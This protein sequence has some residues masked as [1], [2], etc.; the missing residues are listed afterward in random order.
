LHERL[1][2]A[3]LVGQIRGWPLTTYNPNQQLVANRVMLVGD[4][5]GL[6]NP[7]NGEGIQYALLSGKW[8]S[9]TAIS[10]LDANDLKQE[11][12]KHCFYLPQDKIIGFQGSVKISQLR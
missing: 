2:N 1:K 9:E 4:A 6:V 10:C 11:A 12:P 7:L 8:A 3:K 5:A